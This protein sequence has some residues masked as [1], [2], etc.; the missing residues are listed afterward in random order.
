VLVSI[1]TRLR[2]VDGH[3]TIV[4]SHPQVL[5]V[6][7]L[8]GLDQVFLIRLTFADVVVQPSPRRDRAGDRFLASQ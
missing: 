6:F 5:K 4:C 1:R 2:P 8:T 7:R 3:L